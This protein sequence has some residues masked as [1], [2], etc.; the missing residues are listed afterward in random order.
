M[1]RGFL[2]PFVWCTL[3]FV[4][5]A[6]I[7]DIFSFIDDIVKFKIPLASIAAF[8][9][10]YTPTIFIQ[11]TPMAVLLSTIYVLSNLNKHNEITAMK[12]SGVSLWRILKP[13]LIIGFIISVFVFIVNDRVIP[14]SSKI[15]NVIRRDELEKDKNKDR[16]QGVINSVAVYGSGNRIIFARNYDVGNKTLGDIIIHEHDKKSNLVSKM[17]AQ[18]GVWTSEG[19][20]FNKVIMWRIDN[21]GRILGDPEFFSEKIIPLKEKPSDFASREWRSEYMTYRQLRGYIKNFRGAGT[22]IVRSLLVDL[23]YKI[24]FALIS[25]IIIAI[26]APFALITTRGGVLIGIGMSIVI[27]LMYYAFIA[28]ALALGKGGMLPP[29]VAAWIGNA[30]FAVIGVYLVNKRA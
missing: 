16:K 3:V 13:I 9:V 22:R 30:V 14:V 29:F 23:H 21:S 19:W 8:Y 1:V 15:S 20:K 2:S 28:V 18:S 7:I 27:G 24:S 17:T 10:Y 12:S 6:V 25:L 5:M 4:I 26:G 11:V